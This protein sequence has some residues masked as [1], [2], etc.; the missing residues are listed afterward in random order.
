MAEHAHGHEPIRVV[1]LRHARRGEERLDVV[2]L[3]LSLG[4]EEARLVEVDRGIRRLNVAPA[5]DAREE[6]FG[7]LDDLIRVEVARRHEEQA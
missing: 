4:G 3:D 5:R 7:L 2:G 6:G 1:G